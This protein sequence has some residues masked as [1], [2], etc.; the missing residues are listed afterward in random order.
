MLSLSGLRVFCL[1]TIR[2]YTQYY[3]R[4][5]I[6]ALVNSKDVVHLSSV[7]WDVLGELMKTEAVLN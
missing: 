3:T 6:L 4:V 2:L 7:G 1:S 5:S